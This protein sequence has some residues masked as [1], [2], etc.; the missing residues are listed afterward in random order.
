MNKKFLCI[1]IV[2]TFLTFSN[3][4]IGGKAPREGWEDQNGTSAPAVVRKA[5]D[6]LWNAVEIEGG[7]AF[8]AGWGVMRRKG[9]VQQHWLTR[10][11]FCIFTC[12]VTE[13]LNSDALV[14]TKL[15]EFDWRDFYNQPRVVMDQRTKEMTTAL[16]VFRNAVNSNVAHPVAYSGDANVCNLGDWVEDGVRQ[17]NPPGMYHCFS[18]HRN[19]SHVQHFTMQFVKDHGGWNNMPSTETTRLIK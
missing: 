6:D 11:C 9:E 14:N 7:A 5:A 3:S 1:S 4:A 12:G 17:I 8:D 18:G 13:C 16:D 15:N 10:G 2:L 19:L